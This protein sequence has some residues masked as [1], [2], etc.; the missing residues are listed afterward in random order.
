F[1]GGGIYSDGVSLTLS[2]PTF[3]RNQAVSPFGA[4]CGLG[5]AVFTIP[6]RRSQVSLRFCKA[7][8]LRNI[9]CIHKVADLALEVPSRDSE[10][11]GTLMFCGGVKTLGYSVPEGWKETRNCTA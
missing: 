5:G 8:F 11:S 1:H 9:G 2:Q 3:K 7:F 10:F 4:R 6:G